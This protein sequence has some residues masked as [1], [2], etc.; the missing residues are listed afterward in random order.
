M[1][2]KSTDTKYVARGR[3]KAVLAMTDVS[4]W[5][6][7]ATKFILICRIL[8]DIGSR[9]SGGRHDI[10]D[11]VNGPVPKF[12]LDGTFGSAPERT[13]MLVP[14]PP[15]TEG[16][17]GGILISARWAELDYHMHL[18]VD[19]Y[20]WRIHAFSLPDDSDGGAALLA[21]MLKSAMGEYAVDGIPMPRVVS[22]FMDVSYVKTV[23][24]QQGLDAWSSGEE[25]ISLK[26]SGLNAR[27]HS[28][29]GTG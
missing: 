3:S 9:A 6:G 21:G 8:L 24:P 27:P 20:T 10:V 15:K 7:H 19:P 17:D 5:P 12:D 16:A 1:R 11:E 29:T 4:E 18:M 28:Q 14:P 25:L 13:T 23:G 2:I 22:K 26:K